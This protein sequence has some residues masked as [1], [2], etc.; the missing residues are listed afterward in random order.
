MSIHYCADLE[1]IKYV[2]RTVISG[3]QLSVYGT[4]ADM[5]EDCDTCH[6]GA[7]QFVVEGQS[8]PLFVPSVMKTHIPLTDDLARQEEEDLLQRYQERIEK[9][10]QQDGVSKFC[11]D[12]GFLTT[13]EVKTVFHDERH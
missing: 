3:N 4:V 6:D 9:L 12:T 7:R 11:T 5:C 13:A 8:N 2:F 10:S 1:T